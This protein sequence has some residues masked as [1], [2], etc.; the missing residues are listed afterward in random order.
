MGE[1][2]PRRADVAARD[3]AQ[4]LHDRRQRKL[5][6]VSRDMGRQAKEI[7]FENNAIRGPD[8]PDAAGFIRDAQITRKKLQGLV[9][10][11]PAGDDI[12]KNARVARIDLFGQMQAEGVV[13]QRVGREVEEFALADRRDPI[14]NGAGGGNGLL[15]FLLRQPSLTNQRRDRNL[16]PAQFR[17]RLLRG[18]AARRQERL[19]V[20]IA[21][22][23]SAT[24]QSPWRD[25][26]AVWRME[27]SGASRC[28]TFVQ[29]ETRRPERER[30]ASVRL[31]SAEPV[32]TPERIARFAVLL[33]DEP[34]SGPP[35]FRQ[36]RARLPIDDARGP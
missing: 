13:A 19:F 33:R 5:G 17:H 9:N 12:E 4:G 1:G 10:V 18:E 27:S 11:F 36:A 35:E 31:V 20:S 32:I 34:P 25:L 28:C 23:F 30:Q 3:F 14:L 8:E 24:L 16:A 29:S 22:H 26:A 15:G 2:D 6:V 21:G 7:P